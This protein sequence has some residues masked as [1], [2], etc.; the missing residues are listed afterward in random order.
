MNRLRAVGFMGLLFLF[1]SKGSFAQTDD[2]P[3][4]SI[5][6]YEI[7]ISYNQTTNLIFPYAIKSVDRGSGSV[8]A[9]K[10]K[11]VENILQLKAGKEGFTPTN[12][13]VVTADGKFYSFVLNYADQ[14]S[15]L[16]INFAG[17]D[18]VQL[19]GEP[20]NAWQLE[21]VACQVLSQPRFM[22]LQRSD[23]A[24]NMRLNG[25]FLSDNNLWLKLRIGNHSQVDFQPAYMRFFLRDKKRTKRTAL[26]ETELTP[27]YMPPLKI[28]KGLSSSVWTVGFKP[29]TVPKHQRLVIQLGDE[30]GG[31]VLLLRI[32]SRFF[33]RA[34]K[35]PS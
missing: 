20:A 13:S 19:T 9:Q 35:L 31:R 4:T 16:N 34:H 29:F 8:L 23:Q 17:G 32:K 12:V 6:P 10:A 3:V 21:R 25:I 15:H 1:S 27:V 22:G 2:A 30:S 11:G 28:T 24:L 18:P 26:N 5:K 7:A 14:P 33:L